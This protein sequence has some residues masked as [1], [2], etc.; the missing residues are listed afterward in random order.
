MTQYY[1]DPTRESNPHALPD[2]EVFYIGEEEDFQLPPGWYWWVCFPGCLPASD[3][4]GPFNT[5]AEALA[6]AREEA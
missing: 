1:R 3:A 6:D 2:L 5:K 4:M